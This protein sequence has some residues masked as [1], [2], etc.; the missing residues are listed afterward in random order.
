M[1]LVGEAETCN[2]RSGG[3]SETQLLPEEWGLHT[4]FRD[5]NPWDLPW[6][7]KSPKYLAPKTNK[8]Y[9]QDS[10][11]AERKE[12]S[13]L[14]GFV[15]RLNH[16]GPQHKS[17]GVKSTQ[18]SGQGGSLADPSLSAWDVGVW[19]DF[20]QGRRHWRVPFLHTHFSLPAP[21]RIIFALL[22]PC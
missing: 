21:A 8:T 18:T 14:R 15:C 20:L 10:Q 13:N 6:R 2:P 1:R 11:K 19:S 7:E 12:K 9:V 22:L 17:S 16:L 4:P 3:I 5:P